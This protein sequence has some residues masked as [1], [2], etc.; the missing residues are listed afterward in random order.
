M[1][2]PQI[3]YYLYVSLAACRAR[4]GDGLAILTEPKAGTD[5]GLQLY[6]RRYLER[7]L[8][9]PYL[10][11]LVVFYA[12]SVGSGEAH[13]LVP[14][15]RK[16]KAA[17]RGGHPDER[18]LAAGTG[19]THRVLHRRRGPH[20][21]EHP[22]RPT[23]DDR[24]ADL[25]LVTLRAEH[26]GERSVRLLRMH[27][28]VGSEPQGLLSLALVLGDADHAPGARQLPQRGD[29]EEADAAGPDHEHRLVRVRPER[30]V[31]GAGE[32]LY[33]HR[34][35][36]GNSFRDS[37]K[38]GGMSDERPLR[39]APAGVAAEAGLDAGGYRPLR[40]V[41]AQ[42]VISG[43]AV[44]TGRLYA[45]HRAAQSRL[46]HNPFAGA[47]VTALFGYG[48]HD[49][50]AQDQ[51]RGGDRGEVRRVLRRERPQ[52]RAADA[53]EKGF[54]AHPFGGRELG[55]RYLFEL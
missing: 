30:R 21:L 14:E 22:V 40:N 23:H 38:L 20:A 26:G 4:R 3:E 8:E 5:H 6:L 49:L 10:L 19:E 50:V 24:L 37:V 41:H 32:R 34:R 25:R 33:G 18:D 55:L 36:V 28:L 29:D 7:E 35:L 53:R 2:A 47:E 52:I 9:A 16:V 17:P 31:H 44:A 43:G 45:A 12:V 1:L 27:H 42:R 11:S 48:A 51:G 15:G 39:P 46:Q 13:L 54:D